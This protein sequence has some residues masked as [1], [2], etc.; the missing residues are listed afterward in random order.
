MMAD[1]AR[2]LKS[3]DAPLRPARLGP[4]DFLLDR[5]PDGAII[6]RSPH[7]LEHYPDRLTERLE[8]WASAAPDRVFLA[9]RAADGSWRRLTYAQTLAQVRAIAQALL[10]RRLS[11][12]RPIAIL[13]GN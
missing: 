3:A 5:R 9:Q 12:E 13:S 8:H 11:A 1:P 4:A 7:P 6:I 2:N 10:E